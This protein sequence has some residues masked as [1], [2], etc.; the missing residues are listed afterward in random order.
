[1]NRGADGAPHCSLPKSQLLF[2]CI[3]GRLAAGWGGGWRG[4]PYRARECELCSFR[5][6]E[7][8]RSDR[9][10]AS[11]RLDEPF[12]VLLYLVLGGSCFLLTQVLKCRLR[13][14]K[15]IYRKTD[16]RAGCPLSTQHQGP[17]PVITILGLLGTCRSIPEPRPGRGY[18]VHASHGCPWFCP[19]SFSGPGFYLEHQ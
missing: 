9:A 2:L 5:P 8:E 15:Q 7:G 12:T 18:P 3:T 4:A 1:M 14:L 17:S 19:L 10:S 16:Y 6:E 13:F 11:L